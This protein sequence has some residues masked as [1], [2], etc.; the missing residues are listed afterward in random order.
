MQ[1][2]AF[3][4]SYVSLERYIISNSEIYYFNFEELPNFKNLEYLDLSYNKIPDLPILETPKLNTLLMNGNRVSEITNLTF[5]GSP[6]LMQISLTNV[7][8]KEIYF[9]AFSSL[10]QIRFLYLS[11][12]NIT[13]LRSGAIVA[14]ENTL[15]T[16]RLENNDPLSVEK[17]AIEGKLSRHD[18]IIVGPA[19]FHRYTSLMCSFNDALISVNCRMI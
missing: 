15:H 6:W 19:R 9:G 10:Q 3:Q 7:G 12:N 11:N 1:L 14:P 16:L 17:D 8:L 13:A 4:K 5:S 2:N 18:G